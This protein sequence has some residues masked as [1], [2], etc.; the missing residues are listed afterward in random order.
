MMSAM[1]S[2]ITGVPIVCSTVC[3]G[4]DQRKHQCSA[5]LAFVKGIH[6]SPVDSPHKGPVTRKMLPFDD[7][8]MWHWY[9]TFA[10]YL[11]WREWCDLS[12]DLS[13]ISEDLQRELTSLYQWVQLSKHCNFW[14]VGLYFYNLRLCKDIYV[15]TSVNILQI[16]DIDLT[17]LDG[18]CNPT[19]FHW[20]RWNRNVLI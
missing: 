11:V 18:H 1:A 7:V 9:S 2:Q 8:I 13:D 12:K 15:I 14:L 5:S 17:V 3:S 16:P 20:N 10:G 4:A 6:R 19:L